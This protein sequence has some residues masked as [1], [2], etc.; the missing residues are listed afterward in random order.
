M[1]ES[2]ATTFASIVVLGLGFALAGY[3]YHKS[4]KILVMNKMLNA[5]TPGDPV[6]EL[7]AIGKDVPHAHQNVIDQ[8]WVQRPEQ[9]RVDDIVAGTDIGH[10]YLIIGEKGTGKSSMLIEAMRKIDGDGVAMFEAHADL[11]IVRSRLGKALDYEYHEDYIGGYFSE[12]GPRE[13]TALLDIERAL[14]KLEKVAVKMRR[15]RKKPLVVIVNQ[16]H[17]L[18]NDEDGRDLIELLQQKAEQ[19]AAANIVSMIFNSDDFWV[20]ER[21]KLLATRMEVIPVT[22][23]PREQA[24]D[25]LSRYR[26]RYFHE[27]LTVRQLEDVYEQVGGRLSFLNKVSK[28]RDMVKACEAIKEIEKRWFLNQCWILGSTMDDDVMDQ[29]KWA[30]AAMVLAK[31]LVDKGVDTQSTY[32]PEVGHLLPSFH[33]HIAQQ[34][35]TRCDF[36]RELDAL[37]LFSITS[38]AEVRP[39]SVPMF[40]AFQEICSEPG[41]DKLLEDTIERISEIESLG[42]TREL[43]AKDLVL[44]GQYEVA[45]L[46]KGLSVRLQEKE[47]A[48]TDGNA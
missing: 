22:D 12:K 20:Y 43:V 40:R 11:E 14:N 45:K 17:L 15:T 2:A 27:D 18:R 10:Y 3:M 35:M 32:D 25:A 16:M 6:L 24:L 41:F 34:L 33:F 46:A 8:H 30:A 47:E 37:N 13:S 9:Q 5:F 29:Q 26:K 7:A 23:L 36:I 39:S 4:Y 1:L 38:H 48:S 31:A 42:R 21:L 44:G 19:W 28:H